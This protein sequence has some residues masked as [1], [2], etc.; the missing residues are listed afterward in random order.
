MSFS[1]LR[2]YQTVNHLISLYIRSLPKCEALPVGCGSSVLALGG[3]P[4]LLL[5]VVGPMMEICR[6][7]K[8]CSASGFC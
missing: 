8:Y 7:R 1:F 5:A 2:S 6:L 3:M 4:E